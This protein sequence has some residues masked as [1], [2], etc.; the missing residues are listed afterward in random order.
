[1][2]KQGL[3]VSRSE[4]MLASLSFPYQ[5]SVFA[6]SY[7]LIFSNPENAELLKLFL[8]EERLA[9]LLA[10][11]QNEPRPFDGQ[12]IP[13]ERTISKETL[14][15]AITCAR[16]LAQ[17]GMSTIMIPQDEMLDISQIFAGITANQ[18][19][20]MQNARQYLR[21][22]SELGIPRI[23]GVI[24]VLIDTQLTH[25]S[26]YSFTAKDILRDLETANGST[27]FTPFEARVIVA[28]TY[29]GAQRYEND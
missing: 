26:Y 17:R 22:P 9:K 29:F 1:M 8:E 15:Q 20:Q 13:E 14:T 28:L 6:P 18:S 16:Q 19:L 3:E 25:S 10:G 12:P 27:N 21:N 7:G 5:P 4:A 24:E 2:I 23:G 11:P